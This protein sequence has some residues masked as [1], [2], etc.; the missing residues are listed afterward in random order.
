[1]QKRGCGVGKRL[2]RFVDFGALHG[3]E[4]FDLTQR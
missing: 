2:F 1:M 4:T 3:R